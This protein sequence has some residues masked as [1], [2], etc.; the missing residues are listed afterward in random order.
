MKVAC[1]TPLPPTRSGIAH[2]ATLLLPHLAK[3]VDL[4]AADPNIDGAPAYGGCRTIA[5]SAYRRE[6]YDAAIYQLGNNPFHEAIYDEA[7]VNPGVAVLHDAVLHHLIVEKTLARGDVDGYVDA[8]RR[9]HGAAGEAW[10]RGRA[11]G[12]HDEIGNFLFPAS[13]EVAQRSKAVIV[14]NA[15]AADKLRSFGVTT[16]IHVIPHP[17]VPFPEGVDRDAIRRRLGFAGRHRVIGLFG[18]L[19]SAKRGEVVIEAFR[20]ARAKNRDLR[21]L[22]V[23]EPAPNID[24]AQLAGDGVVTT[25]YV[26]DDDFDLYYAAADRL[27]NLRYPSAGETSGT[28]IR[29]LAAGKPVV[30]SDYA[31]FAEYGDAGAVRI[32][33]GDGEVERLAE[34]FLSEIDLDVLGA[35]ERRWLVEHGPLDATIAGYVAALNRAAARVP[36]AAA[37]GTLPLFAEL[38]ADVAT[39]PAGLDVTLTNVG[40]TTLRTRSYGTPGYRLIAKLFRGDIELA[41]RWIELPRDLAPGESARITLPWSDG[42]ATLRLYHAAEGLPLLDGPPWHE[43]S[44]HAR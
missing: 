27:V 44:L 37:V 41:D 23:G 11:A 13:V 33:F 10:A 2:Y 14:H 18:F 20:R 17:W 32:P 35:L 22:I 4:T 26:A 15:W 42:G 7:L 24:V 29:A 25:G 28:L 8:M 38:T 19:T 34:F 21:L 43:E 3:A 6:D 12:L 9:N 39:K 1:L 40:T 5:F 31:Q 16:P 36:S 30:V